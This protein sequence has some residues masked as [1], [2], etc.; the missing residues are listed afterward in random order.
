MPVNYWRVLGPWFE[1]QLGTTESQEI[2][3]CLV[4]KAEQLVIRLRIK[5]HVRGK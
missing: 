4:G 5:A 3:L 2:P 1:K